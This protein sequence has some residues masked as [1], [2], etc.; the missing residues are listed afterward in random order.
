V[1]L[2][3]L[4][5]PDARRPKRADALF[6]AVIVVLLMAL[7][8]FAPETVLLYDRPLEMERLL[9]LHLKAESPLPQLLLDASSGQVI[10]AGIVAIGDGLIA[11]VAFPLEITHTILRLVLAFGVTFFGLKMLGDHLHMPGRTQP[12]FFSNA[13]VFLAAFGPFALSASQVGASTLI[14]ML[15]ALPLLREVFVFAAER[16]SVFELPLRIVGLVLFGGVPGLV[17]A[18]ILWG[19]MTIIVSLLK[20]RDAFPACCLGIVVI[21]VIAAVMLLLPTGNPAPGSGW[22]SPLMWLPIVALLLI[23]APCFMLVDTHDLAQFTR[24]LIVP[25]VTIV[26]LGLMTA[27]TGSGLLALVTAIL[28]AYAAASALTFPEFTYDAEGFSANLQNAVIAIWL[29]L[30]IV[31]V[32]VYFYQLGISAAVLAPLAFVGVSVLGLVTYLFLSPNVEGSRWAMV[33]V[34]MASAFF[35]AFGGA[36]QQRSVHAAASMQHG[37][38]LWSSCRDY[39][40]SEEPEIVVARHVDPRILRWLGPYAWWTDARDP[41]AAM[42]PDALMLA[43][44]SEVASVSRLDLM[45]FNPPNDGKI[46]I[47]AIGNPS[48]ISHRRCGSSEVAA[49]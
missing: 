36:P 40:A 43:H 23:V 44:A 26:A 6:G 39:T 24:N 32:A 34:S 17:L 9:A 7:A 14:C 46:L 28:V 45:G 21:A 47:L 22:S 3:D 13:F 16:A 10:V 31:I 38:V 5:S 30:P 15:I 18:S 29:L 1:S 37:F 25:A 27:V 12:W 8:L 35:L 19:A 33:L 41:F 48:E 11:R 49:P 42:P 4:P 2:L 20:K